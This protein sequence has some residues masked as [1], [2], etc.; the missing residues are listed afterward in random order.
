MSDSGALAA[1]DDYANPFA[2]DP[3]TSALFDSFDAP[4]PKRDPKPEPEPEAVVAPV[5]PRPK[6]APAPKQA[7]ALSPEKAAEAVSEKA[8][9]HSR[10]KNKKKVRR[11]ASYETGRNKPISLKGRDEDYALLNKLCD[12]QEWVKGQALQYA[13]EALAE[14][15]AD[16]ESPFWDE[17]NYHGVD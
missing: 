5:T 2:E 9:F 10:K 6:P 3:D 15:V 17:R 1:A 12:A 8:G 14:K 4:A 16:P 7:K 13:L 11:S